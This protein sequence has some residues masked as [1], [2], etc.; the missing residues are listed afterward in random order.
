MVKLKLGHISRKFAL[1]GHNISLGAAVRHAQVREELESSL[2][3]YL[4]FN[5]FHYSV[6]LTL[7]NLVLSIGIR[8]SI[9]FLLV[10]HCSY[11]TGIN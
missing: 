3:I 1:L 4:I 11:N 5:S 2:G 7:Y 9:F 10:L 6:A 8:A